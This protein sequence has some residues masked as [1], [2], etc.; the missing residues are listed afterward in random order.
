MSTNNVKGFFDYGIFA[1]KLKNDYVLGNEYRFDKFFS[2]IFDEINRNYSLITEKYYDSLFD[3]IYDVMKKEYE[4]SDKENFNINAGRYMNTALEPAN[5][6]I[7][8]LEKNKKD[9][10][11][12]GEF[13][14]NDD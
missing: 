7:L 1:G 9:S 13:I 6:L 5:R 4:S 12:M 14:S 10:E 3:E 2:D 8:K 11:E